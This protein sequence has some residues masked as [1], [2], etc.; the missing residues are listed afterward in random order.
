M[1][2]PVEYLV[3]AREDFDASFDWY[4]RRDTRAAVRFASAVDIA[5]ENII[6]DPQR[7]PAAPGD[8]QYA[9]LQRYPFQLVFREEARRIVVVAIAHAKRR[10]DYWLERTDSAEDSQ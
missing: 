10:P 3:Q 7:F 5:I 8:C 6:A 1:G 4:A 2:K 9:L